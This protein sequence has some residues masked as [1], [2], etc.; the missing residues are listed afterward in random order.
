[1]DDI[2]FL[3]GNPYK[4]SYATIASWVGE[5]PKNDKFGHWGT[6][7]S[8][9]T[10]DDTTGSQGRNHRSVHGAFLARRRDLQKKTHVSLVNQLL[11]WLLPFPHIIMEVEELP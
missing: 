6:T 2:T 4:P 10:S 1:M 3:V 11:G 5:T 9:S 8:P 7:K